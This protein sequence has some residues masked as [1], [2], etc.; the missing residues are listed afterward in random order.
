[1][2]P[3]PPT[4]DTREALHSDGWALYFGLMALMAGALLVV[5]P[6]VVFACLWDRAWS[7]A[8]VTGMMLTGAAVAL[9]NILRADSS[10]W[11]TDAGVEFGEEPVRVPWQRV[12]EAT[13]AFFGAGGFYTL[14]FTDGTREVRFFGAAD[15]YERLA[16]RKARAAKAP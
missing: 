11:M 4:D 10:V 5:L 14:T 1:M 7:D 2:N 16:G 13:P 15:A 12:G 8:A 6:V 9:R 3:A